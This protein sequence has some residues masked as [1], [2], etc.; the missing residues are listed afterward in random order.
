MNKN[1]NWLKELNILTGE[2]LIGRTTK[3][4]AA[5]HK[6]SPHFFG[7]NSSKLFTA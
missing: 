7:K 1:E 2:H 5:L 6:C 3:E 4:S